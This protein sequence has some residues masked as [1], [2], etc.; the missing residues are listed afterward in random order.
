MKTVPKS[1]KSNLNGFS[2]HLTVSVEQAR[3]KS[4]YGIC[5]RSEEYCL[6]QIHFKIIIFQNDWI[7]LIKSESDVGNN[8]WW[9]PIEH[10][11]DKIIM[12]ATFKLCWWFF[13][14]MK[15]VTNI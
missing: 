6:Q 12:F 3:Q 8:L 5:K 13:Q 9:W 15:S 1:V 11:G 4:G 14:R 2:R 7:I 10:V